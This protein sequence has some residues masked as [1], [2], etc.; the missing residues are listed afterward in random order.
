MLGDPRFP[1]GTWATTDDGS[2]GPVA[3]EVSGEPAEADKRWTNA[4]G[5]AKKVGKYF[6]HGI[7]LVAL[8]TAFILGWIFLAA[9]FVLFGFIFG[10]IIALAL[11][12]IGTGFVNSLVTRLLWFPVKK[13]WKSYLGHGLLLG[14]TLFLV[15]AVPRL[16]VFTSLGLGLTTENVVLLV[17]LNTGYTFVDGVIGKRVAR[18]WQTGREYGTTEALAASA[19]RPQPNPKNPDELRCPRC[20]GIRLVVEADRSAYC[21]DCRKGIHPTLWTARSSL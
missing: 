12:F 9:F 3:E 2:T 20:G 8:G 11:L 17:L 10:L 14:V 19:A 1:G 18:I 15:E 5:V 4:K 7:L 21:V 13:G 16:F 6:L